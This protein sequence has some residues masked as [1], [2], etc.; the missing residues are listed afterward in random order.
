MREKA[1]IGR[2]MGLLENIWHQQ[3]DIRFNQLIDNLKRMYSAQNDGFGTRKV[4]E[5]DSFGNDVESS[6]LDF[7]YLEDDKWKTFLESLVEKEGKHK[8]Y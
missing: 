5:K 8:E 1:R 3:P 2:I 4:K 6:Y 7:F